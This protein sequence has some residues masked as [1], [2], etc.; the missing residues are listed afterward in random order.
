MR[1]LVAF[2]ACALPIVTTAPLQAADLPAWAKPALA[3][4]ADDTS[5]A[6]VLVDDIAVVVDR[7]G[8]VRTTERYVVRINRAEARSAASIR[9]VYVEGSGQ[10]TGLKAWIVPPRGNAREYGGRETFEVALVDNDLYNEIRA[11]GIDAAEDVEPGST[12]VAEIQSE[13]RG[14]FAQLEWT[15]QNRWPV[16]TARR[17]L[18]LPAGWT[19]R[20]VTFNAAAIEPQVAGSTYAWELRNLPQLHEEPASPPVS[21]LAPRLAVSYFAGGG[22]RLGGQFS[23]W[24]DVAAWL[25]TISEPSASASER[26]SSTAREIVGSAATEIDKV[27]AIARFVQRVQYVSIQTGLGRGGGYQPRPAAQTLDTRYGDCKDKAN[28]MRALLAAVGIKSHLVAIYSG[29]PRYVREE[30]PSPQQFNHCIIAIVLTQPIELGTVV[31]HASLGRLLFFDPT[32]ERGRVGELPVDE[33]GSL[34]LLQVAGGT[35]E[36]IPMLPAETNRIDRS[37]AASIE[38]SGA[39]TATVVERAFGRAAATARARAAATNVDDFRRHLEAEVATMAPGAKLVRHTAEASADDAHYTV[40]LEA[41]A[42]RYGQLMQGRLMIV[43]PPATAGV[44]AIALAPGTRRYP[45]DLDAQHAV[46]QITLKL[47]P[48]FSVDELPPPA[49]LESPYARF[50]MTVERTPD[51]GVVSRRRFEM[52]R[53]LVPTSEYAT[54]RTFLDR[55]RAAATAPIVLVKQ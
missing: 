24:G 15:L 35:L 46:E 28:L 20:S 2:V 9:Q 21:S 12:F 25:H 17:T 49:T 45:V 40:T 5:A 29:D 19:A 41:G 7:D 44:D 18:T 53:A 26:L 55:V 11:K 39:L 50:T 4:P 34:A 13:E 48:G 52:Q 33:Q 10:V 3:A 42:S 30:W 31:T 8:K 1:Q 14:L 51:G 38:A 6:T 16:R 27:R 32:D 36:R 23:S 22:E 47:P 37:V 54:L 43:R